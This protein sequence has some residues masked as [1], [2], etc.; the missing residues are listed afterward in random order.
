MYDIDFWGAQEDIVI[1]DSYTKK[2]REFFDIEDWDLEQA[3]K[4]FDLRL[5]KDSRDFIREAS[6]FFASDILGCDYLND[7][8][9][10]PIED[11]EESKQNWIENKKTL[12][13][14]LEGT[15]IPG[16]T[17]LQ[18]AVNLVSS[19]KEAQQNNPGSSLSDQIDQAIANMDNA[20]DLLDD[21]ELKEVMV[22]NKQSYNPF[23]KVN[24]TNLNKIGLIEHLGA[25]FKIEKQLETNEV[26]NGKIPATKKM[27]KYSQIE[28]MDFTQ[29]LYPNFDVKFLKKDLRINTRLDRIEHKQKIICIIDSSGSMNNA[30]KQRWIAT[31]LVDRLRFVM[32]EEAE[33]FIGYYDHGVHNM[34]HI[35]DKKTALQFWTNYEFEADAGGTNLGGAIGQVKK[36]IE[37]G[38]FFNLNIDLSEDED[39]EILVV[40]D[41]NDSISGTFPWKVNAL[42]L[43]DSLNKGLRDMCVQSDGKYIYITETG[44]EEFSKTTH[45][46]TKFKI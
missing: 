22:A 1:F 34:K 6:Y 21:E 42:T 37:G 25:E 33:M 9:N 18:Q 26:N 45:K 44:I 15:F 12:Y 27:T 20:V 31:L 13:N 14:K 41:A 30:V 2:P 3:A 16:K 35:Y 23:K 38:N 29:M 24:F 10:K 5:D 11:F 4:V 36:Q 8:Y 28:K 39:I 32:R 46:K 17:P 7:E 19:L 40:S 43:M